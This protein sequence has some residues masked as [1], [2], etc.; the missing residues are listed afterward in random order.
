MYAADNTS[1]IHTADPFVDA[2]DYH[3]ANRNEFTFHPIGI[4]DSTLDNMMTLS[5]FASALGHTY[6]DIL[7]MDVEGGEMYSIP[8]ALKDPKRPIIHQILIEVHTN[9][10]PGNQ[11]L[12]RRFYDSLTDAGYVMVNA[13]FNSLTST[14]LCLY[15]YVYVHR[16][17]GLLLVK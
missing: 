12:V 2:T 15:E 6:I 10:G 11:G 3:V 4:A 9:P 7:K 16:D 14:N 1:I 13:E 8:Q 5:D 17:S